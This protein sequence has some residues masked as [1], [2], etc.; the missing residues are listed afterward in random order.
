MEDLIKGVLGILL[1]LSPV[2]L[3]MWFDSDGEGKSKKETTE[4]K[5][6]TKNL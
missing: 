3:L 6:I 1:G 5:S 2:L 4:S